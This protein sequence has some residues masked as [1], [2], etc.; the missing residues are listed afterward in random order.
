[1]HAPAS[2]QHTNDDCRRQQ[3]IEGQRVGMNQPEAYAERDFADVDNQ[4]EPGRR[5]Q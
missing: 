1:M 5:C 2:Q 4:K 3:R